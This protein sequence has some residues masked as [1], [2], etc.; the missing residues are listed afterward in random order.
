[1]GLVPV[2]RLAETAGLHQLLEKHLSVESPNPVAKSASIV[3]GMPAGADS[4]GD[5]DIRRHGAMGRLFGGVRAPSTLGT[6]L[7]TFT[8]GRIQQLDALAAGLL[9]GL[10]ARVPDLLAGADQI[11]FVDVETPSAGVA[12]RS[13]PVWKVWS[14]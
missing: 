7:C 1:G 6:H 3:A 10:T 2:M 5:L 4:I 14:G 9:A 12:D 8:H 13:S 11:A